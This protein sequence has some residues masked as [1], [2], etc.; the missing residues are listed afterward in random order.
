M[1]PWFMVPSARQASCNVGN[2][3]HDSVGS[4]LPCF[5][6]LVKEPSPAIEQVFTK[7]F[8]RPQNRR[9]QNV[10][11]E[12]LKLVFRNEMSTVLK[13]RCAAAHW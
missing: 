10:R 9:S 4:S 3:Y 1:V 12:Q 8:R 13:A 11:T 6:E 7:Q 2:P 5:L